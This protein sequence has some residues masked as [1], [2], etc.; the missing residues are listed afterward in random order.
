MGDVPTT[1]PPDRGSVLTGLGMGCLANLGLLLIMWLIVLAFPKGGLYV[2]SFFGL[3]Q[4]AYVIP[5][6]LHYRKLGAG[7][8]MAGIIIMAALSLLFTASC[9]ALLISFDSGSMH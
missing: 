9:G 4:L 2:F 3:I 6:F 5:M 8:T 1:I 7:N